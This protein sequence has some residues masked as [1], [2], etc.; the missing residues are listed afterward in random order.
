MSRIVDYYTAEGRDSGGRKFTDF[1]CLGA[2]QL[3]SCHDY[4]QW[5]FPLTEAS[6]YNLDAPILTD[7]DIQVLQADQLAQR[8]LWRAFAKM[9]DFYCVHKHWRLK[10]DHN[11]LRITRILKSLRLLMDRDMAQEF[12][13]TIVAL[14][15]KDQFAAALPYWQAAMGPAPKA[16]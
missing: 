6:R 13:E 12:Y 9:L 8:R 3:E 4:I 10:N 14:P 2:D 1:M 11:L 5:V 7:A 15:E 16:F